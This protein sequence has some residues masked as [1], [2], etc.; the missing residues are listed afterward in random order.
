M[1]DFWRPGCDFAVMDSLMPFTEDCGKLP[2]VIY[3]EILNGLEVLNAGHARGTVRETPFPITQLKLTLETF[4]ADYFAWGGRDFV[5]ERIR[6]VIGPDSSAVRFFEVDASQ[7]AP[8][9]RS[10]NYQIMEVAVAE[11]VS[12]PERSDYR[13]V[14]CGPD[15][16][17]A[18]I[19]VR[20]YAFRPDA[21]PTYDLFHDRFFGTLLCTEAFALRILKSGCTGMRF[22]D[23]SLNQ[24]RSFYRTLRG[25]EEY[26]EWDLINRVEITKVIQA[27]N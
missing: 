22:R 24:G 20:H 4:D 2:E 12:D 5:S 26:I 14:P 19:D 8:L 6:D 15:R 9:P 17:L 16:L 13:M 23:P 18:P 10:K 3:C 1:S 11:D 27:I 7:S 21:A 25:I